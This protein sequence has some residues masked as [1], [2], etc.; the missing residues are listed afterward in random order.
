MPTIP[1]S[2]SSWIVNSS[3]R[4]V[5]GLLMG[6][7]FV[8]YYSPGSTLGN[9][10]N[11]FIA[12][13]SFI[14]PAVLSKHYDE[15]ELD[16]VESIL[17]SSLKYFLALGIPAAF[18]LS[19]LSHPILDVLATPEIAA[20]GYLVTP[21]VAL[22]AL[23]LGTL[24]IV[25]Q[26]ILLEK[27]S[28]L[29]GSIWVVAAFLN[30]GLNFLLIPKIGILGAAITTLLTFAFA[31]A[32]TFYYARKD[33]KI[34]F[35]TAFM[36]KSVIASLIMS[37]FLLILRPSGAG[38]LIVAICIAALLYF[39]VLFLLKGVSKDETAFI[40]TMLNLK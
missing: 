16:E 28:A 20:Q 8:G 19:L 17:G 2:L 6:T 24:A 37:S 25:S 29:S 10:I 12:P 18:G 33:L 13:I 30:L 9:M 22:G 23:F 14:L 7:T 11:L 36:L 31:F 5:I 3:N 39:I 34:H 4:Y 32:I 27:K 35:D 40:K 38:M 21:F 15:S 1:G 26:I